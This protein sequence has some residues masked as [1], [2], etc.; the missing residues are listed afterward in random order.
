MKLLSIIPKPTKAVVLLFPARNPGIQAKH[1]EQDEKIAAE[2]QHT[3]DRTLF[4]VKQKVR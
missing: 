1:K 3:I 4:F 2:G